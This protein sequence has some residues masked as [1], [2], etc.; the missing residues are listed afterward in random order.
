MASWIKCYRCKE[1]FVL[2][3]DTEA[4]LRRSGQ[5]FHC[6]WGHAQR[7][8]LGPS[9]AELLRK[10]RDTLKQRVAMVENQAEEDREGRR[11]AERQAA[12]FKGVATRT[13]NRISKGVC[14]CCNRT[15][16]NLQ[17]HM[18]SKHAGYADAP[19]TVQ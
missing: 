9:E 1:S 10:E 4:T 19:V 3:P 16:A 14:P 13:R 15:F 5:V 18:A 7:F 12:A 11:F 2:H 17:A 8:T 6:P